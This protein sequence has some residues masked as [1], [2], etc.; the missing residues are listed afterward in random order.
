MI[1]AGASNQIAYAIWW[2]RMGGQGAPLMRLQAIAIAEFLKLHGET[3]HIP[4]VTDTIAP[5]HEPEALSQART[6]DAPRKD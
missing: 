3:L 1:A 4:G 5:R 6:P 2:R